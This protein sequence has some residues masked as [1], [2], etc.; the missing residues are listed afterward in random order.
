MTRISAAERNP[1]RSDPIN[2]PFRRTAVKPQ[3]SRWP[4]YIEG[5]AAGPGSGGS[6]SFSLPPCGGGSGWEVAGCG[7][8]VPY[9]PTPTPDPSPQGGGEKKECVD[10]CDS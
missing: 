10:I 2:T 6:G 4:C 7:S 9:F 3:F 8:K 5:C 1:S